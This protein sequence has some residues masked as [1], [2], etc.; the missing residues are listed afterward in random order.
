MQHTSLN[1]SFVTKPISRPQRRWGWFLPESSSRM[2]GLCKL[3]CLLSMI[4]QQRLY[5]RDVYHAKIKNHRVDFLFYS[6]LYIYILL[7]MLGIH[8]PPR[9]IR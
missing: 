2:D 6:N 1:A 3:L 9:P 5:F 8:K 4:L 7:L